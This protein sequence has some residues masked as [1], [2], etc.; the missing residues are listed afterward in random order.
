MRQNDLMVATESD[1]KRFSIVVSLDIHD[2][3]IY[4]YTVD[5]VHGDI[6]T[7]CNLPASI[8]AV[9]MHMSKQQ[10]RKNR[11][12]ILYEAGNAGFVPY[13]RFIR[14]GYA[15]K[16]IAPSS[17]P[18]RAK[19]HKTDRSDAIANLQYYVS[20]LLRYVHVPSEEDA[21]ARELLR[22]RYDLAHQTAKQKQKIIALVKRAGL[23]FN[24]T[25]SN[26]T[27]CH[28]RWLKTATLA[29]CAR[30]LLDM[31]LDNLSALEAQLQR[32]D[33]Q[34]DH[35][36]SSNQR[37]AT[38][39][40]LF[41]LIPG[42]GRVGAMTL[43]LEAQDLRRF[44]HPTALMSYT[45][46]IPGKYASGTSDPALHITKAGNPFLRLAYVAAAKNYRDWRLLLKRSFIEK[47]PGPI[48]EFL[49]RLQHRL[50]SRYRHLCAAGKHS[51]KAKCAVARELCAFTWE[52]AVKIAP[53]INS[54]LSQ[55][56]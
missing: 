36:I 33:Q 8:D 15:C 50:Y 31:M 47:Q 16:I 39:T 34:L 26:W 29:S 52:L 1:N 9:L 14:A 53:T 24:L 42:F 41:S 43:V 7:D 3:N 38:A 54:R 28:R 5:I 44:V 20:G 6:I 48:K 2:S 17:I 12:I 21:D 37:Y 49:N 11:T 10:I 40:N 35:L 13:R 22:F 23:K 25:K 45:G 19:R 51:N 4:A 32:L 30:I 55:A 46:L 56:A 27:L 18:H